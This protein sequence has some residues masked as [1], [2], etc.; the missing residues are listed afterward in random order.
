MKLRFITGLAIAALA[1]SVFADTETFVYTGA[2]QSWF[3]PTGVTEVFIE[4]AGAQGGGSYLSGSG[5]FQ[6]DGGLGGSAEGMLA[7]TAGQVLNIYVGGKAVDVGNITPAPGGYNGGGDGG[8]YGAGGGGA[9][10]V[11][12]DGTALADRVIV[13]AGGGGGNSGGPDHGKGGFG[14][15]LTGGPGIEA[16]SSWVPAGGGTQSAGGAA[17]SSP[18]V[19]GELGLGGSNPSYHI[20]GGGGGYYGGGAAYAAGGGGGSSYI[21]GVQSGST[22]SGTQ[23]GDGELSITFEINEVATVPVPTLSQWALIMLVLLMVMMG[24]FGLR[25]RFTQ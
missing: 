25:R 4:A 20:A 15:G 18:G 22:T 7:V 10:D 8:Q 3:V 24:G 6:D 19:A 17:G 11:R 16:I 5:G 14:G 2:S 21:D 23:T 9:S 1:N 12:L 13:A